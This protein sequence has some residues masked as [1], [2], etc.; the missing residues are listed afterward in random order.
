MKLR[1]KGLCLFALLLSAALFLAGCGG[2]TVT[3]IPVEQVKDISGRWNDTDS[4]L[5]ADEMIRDCLERP[6][7]PDFTAAHGGKRPDI[8][9]GR[10]R[11]K[12]YEHINTETFVID[13]QR[14]I[15]NSGRASFVAANEERED[16][17]K[18]RL[19]QDINAA[20]ASRK[21]P[22]KEA[23]ADYMLSGSI[24]AIVDEEKG[25]KVVFYQVNLVLTS[26]ADNRQVWFGDKKIKK[27]IENGGVRF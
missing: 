8:I 12:S 19:D 13:L 23:G 6:W 7:L 3:R 16:V 10:I 11:N 2:K 20:E 18:E 26:M 14:A 25:E 24:N 21:A 22:G 15:T 1:L 9:V 17:R 27:F 5:V 4:R